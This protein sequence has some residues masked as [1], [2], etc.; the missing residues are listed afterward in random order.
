ML[1]ESSGGGSAMPLGVSRASEPLGTLCLHN[2]VVIIPTMCC[3][4][5]HLVAV[6]YTM[7]CC[8]HHVV[9][10]THTMSCYLQH[11]AVVMFIM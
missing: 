10:V 6:A 4:L 7:W 5:H 9:V 8:L 3:Y 2:L 1:V 11:I